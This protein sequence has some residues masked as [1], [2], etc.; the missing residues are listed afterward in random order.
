MTQ[1][2]LKIGTFYSALIF[3]AE[4]EFYVGDHI[5]Y[6]KGS[7]ASFE[8]TIITLTCYAAA[9]E[10]NKLQYQRGGLLRSPQG[11]PID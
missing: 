1:T 7:F 10:V 6:I 9:H 3:I 8:R 4:A 11:W 2:V 5:I